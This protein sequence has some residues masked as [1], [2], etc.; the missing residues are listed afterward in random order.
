MLSAF[1]LKSNTLVYSTLKTLIVANFENIQLCLYG[2]NSKRN[3]TKLGTAMLVLKV[4]SR[5]L[6]H[7]TRPSDPFTLDHKTGRVMA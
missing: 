6:S 3:V 4:L 5:I 7:V 1:L 2:Q